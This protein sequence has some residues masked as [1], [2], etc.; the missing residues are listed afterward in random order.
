MSLP[1]FHVEHLAEGIQALPADEARHARLARR[2]SVDDRVVLFDGQ[3]HE[4]TATVIACGRRAFEVQAGP[5]KYA[6]RRTPR[7]TLAVAMPKGPRQDMLIE[8]CTELGTAA[9]VPLSSDRSV[10]SVSAH[11]LSKWRQTTIAAAKQSGQAWLPELC[12]PMTL[13]E[14]FAEV[15]AFDQVLV[16]LSSAPAACEEARVAGERNPP[17]PIIDLLPVLRECTSILG[18]VG[19]EGGWTSDEVDTLTQAGIT[20]ISLGPN[21]LRIETAAVALA[22]LIHAVLPRANE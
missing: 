1:R 11:R 14:L 18:V 19:P 12:L 17:S 15:S 6:P 8:K 20:P 4:A 5:V 7:L 9:L 21:I 13:P 16:G 3:G 22:T 10:A 2:L